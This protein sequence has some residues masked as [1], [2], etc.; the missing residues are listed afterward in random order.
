MDNCTGP[1]SSTYYKLMFRLMGWDPH[2]DPQLIL[3]IWNE[4]E[5]EGLLD[6]EHAKEIVSMYA[7]AGN[8]ALVEEYH[9]RARNLALVDFEYYQ[10][11][12]FRLIDSGKADMH[13]VNVFAKE[14]I[15]ECG[16]FDPRKDERIRD[17][18]R[19]SIC[20]VVEGLEGR[21]E[22]TFKVLEDY[23]DDFLFN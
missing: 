16:D 11:L 1:T 5:Y 4:C 10:L 21:K 8:M 19:E 7:G 13:A 9:D 15:E 14:W 3:N 2:H 17:N 12:V 6:A 18:Y 22:K 20:L 23:F